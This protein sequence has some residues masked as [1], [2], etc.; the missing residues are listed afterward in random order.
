MKTRT[1]SAFFMLLIFI[2]ILIAG[3]SW[4]QLL[5]FIISLIGIT[6]FLDIKNSK[7]EIPNFIK[8]ISYMLVS[9]IILFN[10][11]SN[12]NV[13][14]IDYKIIS[15]LFLTLFL[16]T[17]F[18]HE[19]T[20]YSINDAFYLAGGILFLGFSM[21]LIINIR[22]IGLDITVYLFL[23]STMTDTYA[24]ITGS[25]IGRNKMLEAIS[26]KKTWEGFAGG[27]FFGVL[28]PTVYYHT[29]INPE[30]PIVTLVL[31][32]LFLSVLGQFGD[33]FFS[34]I[35]RYFDKKDFSNLVPGH[36]GILDRFDSIIF[37]A[38]GYILFMSIL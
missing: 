15:A 20:K 22:N 17:V 9:L 26:P 18:Y 38:L 34:S 6:E 2:P 5:I 11:N 13:F 3:G 10:I 24:Y 30:L 31:I 35:K 21:S 23:I 36:G 16:P 28:I 19:R 14:M 25:L 12:N 1:I 29:V 37:V 7:K 27:T 8:F 33:L 4:F 32:T